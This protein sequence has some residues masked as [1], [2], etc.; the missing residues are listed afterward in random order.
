MQDQHDFDLDYRYRE[1]AA[2]KRAKAALR[3]YGFH[4]MFPRLEALPRTV[5]ADA[6]EVHRTTGAYSPSADNSPRLLMALALWLFLDT[7]E[8]HPPRDRMTWIADFYKFVGSTPID[9]P[10]ARGRK[11]ARKVRRPGP[12]RTP[13]HRQLREAA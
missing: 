7:Y 1:P 11:R 5:C 2:W 4:V 9:A 13:G 3:G 8:A 6:A 12:A 10:A